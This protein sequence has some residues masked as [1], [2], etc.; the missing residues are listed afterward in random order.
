M[1][2]LIYII[3][4]AALVCIT[5][6]SCEKYLDQAP[7]ENLSIADVF[8]NRI[9]TRDFLTHTYSWTP[10]EA[11]M[12]DDG[13]AW[14]NPYTA[15][16]DELECAY[17]G[18]YGHQINNG[19]WSPNDISRTQV[20][21]ESYMALRKVNMFLSNVDNC[22]EATADEIR[23]WK[24]EAYFLRA[25][26]TFLVFRAYGPVPIVDHALDPNEDMMA[27]KRS[28]ADEVAK[29]IA[30]DCD[31][32]AELL[33]DVDKWGSTDTGR[34]TRLSALGLKSRVLLYIA[35]PLYNGDTMEADLK[36]PETGENL[37]SQTY[38]A[39]KWKVA[40]DA[41]KACLD[42]AKAAGRG[43]YNQYP[44]DPVKNYQ[45]IFNDNWN[46][47][48][49]W[50]KN[51]GTYEH[52][53]NCADPVSFGCFSIIDPTQEM[54]DAYE[55]EDGST[56]ITGYTNNG[57]T[58]VINE[59][60]GYVETGFTTKAR[61]GRW[62]KGVCNMYT[63]RE[64]RFYA[65]INFAGAIWKT[66]RESNWTVPH[67]LE[68]WFNGVDGKGH[69]GSDYCKTGYLMKKMVYPTRIPWT[70]TPLQ[71]WVYI[72]LGEIYLNYA[73]ALNEY[74]G[75]SAEVYDAVNAIRKRAGL[76][77]LASGLTK[78]QMREKIHHERRIELAFEVH[79]F[80]DV[81]RWMIAPETQG[82]P[83]HSMNIWAGNSMQDPTFYTRIKVE[84]RVFET[85][86]HYLFPISQTEIDK[87]ERHL[88][89]QNLGWTTT[90]AKQ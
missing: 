43:L 65:S 52:W 47:E 10:T 7:D 83:I 82:T 26:F 76:P 69:A 49:L 55:M 71:M 51:L 11:N 18:A 13:G 40:A 42:A 38:D 14:R 25:W 56:P 35:S 9:Y 1:K 57:L 24:G 6:V 37:I 33:Y 46:E 8:S 2:R 39:E 5:S 31:Q 67:T 54:V 73:E 60:S 80:F 74:S 23:H 53:L 88:L 79:R 58:P 12:A 20:W 81:R 87:N 75:P 48:I 44:N 3:S 64:P 15:G 4:A 32:A 89:V 41:A 17:G 22:K 28:P 86:K 70:Y 84:D 36:D 34:A 66:S 30:N 68:F 72:R 29:F 61:D 62:Q 90:T 21:P 78:D 77:G 16:C 63:N 45:N 59:A 19:G 27:I 50:A 85:P